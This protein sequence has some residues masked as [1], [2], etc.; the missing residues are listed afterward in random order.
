MRTEPFE[1]RDV[2]TLLA[3]AGGA[4]MAGCLDLEFG[5]VG[6]TGTGDAP[7]FSRWLPASGGR[8]PNR[9]TATYVDVEEL[10]RF[11]ESLPDSSITEF[12]SIIREEFPLEPLGVSLENVDQ[13]VR[14]LGDF[15]L[16]LS[17]SFDETAI[18]NALESQTLE[19]RDEYGDYD[20]YRGVRVSDDERFSM[21]VDSST[22]LFTRPESTTA[23]G[24]TTPDEAAGGEG[25]DPATETSAAAPVTIE[26]LIDTGAGDRDRLQDVNDDVGALLDQVDAPTAL[27]VGVLR[28]TEYV[29]DGWIGQAFTVSIGEERTTERGMFLF[30]DESAVDEAGVEDIV[31]ADDVFE[32]LDD[33][34]IESKGRIAIAEA[35][36]AT[37][38]F[39]PSENSGD[40]ASP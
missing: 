39:D 17:G 3:S 16:V 25:D 36:V 33:L 9:I 34:T 23:S 10:R 21:A 15:P 14:L 35:S 28:E 4:S 22:V 5:G 27:N 6:A 7:L 19:E 8:H 32:S 37:D 11:Q 20:V 31:R 40:T 26:Q 13:L 18:K 1:R 24:E 30:E 29:L 12:T 38:E 2:L